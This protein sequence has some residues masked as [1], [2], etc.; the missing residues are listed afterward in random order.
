M[1]RLETNLPEFFNVSYEEVN[2]NGK[3][4]VLTTSD[5]QTLLEYF[6]NNKHLGFGVEGRLEVVE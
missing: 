5:V 1:I 4:F 2:A 6:E 3:P